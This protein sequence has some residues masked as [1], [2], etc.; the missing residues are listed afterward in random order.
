M[1]II[2]LSFCILINITSFSTFSE[3]SQSDTE[4]DNPFEYSV[5]YGMGGFSESRSPEGVLGGG[6]VAFDIHLTHLPLSFSIS[7]ESYANRADPKYPYEIAR[8]VNANVFYYD[9]FNS[10]DKFSYFLGLGAGKISVPRS[11]TSPKPYVSDS[12]I[13]IASRIH[14]KISTHF[15]LYLLVKH[16]AADKSVNNVDV[17]NYN[18]TIMLFGLG[19]NFQL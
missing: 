15:S 6:Q 8:M 14:Y 5:R 18:D 4:T 7:Q 11:E 16:L 1:K 13:N 19:Y 9:N 10:L 12:Y 2:A 3:T 17:I